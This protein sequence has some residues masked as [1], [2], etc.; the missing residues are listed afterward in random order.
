[1]GVKTFVSRPIG[2]WGVLA[3]IMWTG[4]LSLMSLKVSLLFL[5]PLGMEC[6][7]VIVWVG[8]SVGHNSTLWRIHRDRS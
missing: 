1:M 5:F 2:V 3:I 7:A 8:V 4:F 6:F